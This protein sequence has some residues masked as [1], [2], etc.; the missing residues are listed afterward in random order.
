MR[1][2]QSFCIKHC[3]FYWNCGLTHMKIEIRSP[4]C[5]RRRR[6][7]CSKKTIGSQRH[8]CANVGFWLVD[9]NRSV[10]RI[11]HDKIDSCDAIVGY[12]AIY[13]RP[14]RFTTVYKID[15][16]FWNTKCH[17]MRAHRGNQHSMENLRLIGQPPFLIPK[18]LQFRPIGLPTVGLLENTHLFWVGILRSLQWELRTG[19]TLVLPD[20]KVWKLERNNSLLMQLMNT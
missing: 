5:S 10:G 16:T 6:G 4:H 2:G 19:S 12:T 3:G 13:S 8:H 20:T 17:R 15:V 11:V 1:N 9:I 14:T 18:D 7:N